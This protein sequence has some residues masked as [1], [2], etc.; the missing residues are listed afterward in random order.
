MKNF[1]NNN[2]RH[3]F[4]TNNSD[5][6]HKRNGS[7]HKLNPDFVNS[8][9]FQRRNPNRFNHNASKLI[10]K[11]ND[12]G[13]EALSK[14]DKILSESYFQ[15][16]DHFLRILNEQNQEKNQDK[17]DIKEKKEKEEV[18]ETENKDSKIFE[19]TKQTA[20]N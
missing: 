4:R 18:K 3:R 2:K 16:S 13:R 8:S 10:D 7:I 20:N 11:Y 12:L 5:R 9:N 15:H 19:V 17:S 14:G 1:R 6:N